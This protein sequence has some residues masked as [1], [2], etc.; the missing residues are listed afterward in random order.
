[1]NDKF[2]VLWQE[3]NSKINQIIGKLIV[4]AMSGKDP[5]VKEAHQNLIDF[6]NWFDEE[7]EKLSN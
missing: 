1:M 6:A 4:P 3:H 2:D 5:I 7:M